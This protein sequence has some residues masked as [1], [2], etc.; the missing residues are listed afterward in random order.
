VT[1]AAGGQAQVFAAGEGVGKRPQT[2]EQNQED[3]EC[4]PHLELMIQD[5]RARRRNRQA[6]V[7]YHRGIAKE[8]SMRRL[9]LLATLV[10]LSPSIMAQRQAPTLSP[11]DLKAAD[12]EFT[13]YIS[14]RLLVLHE[15]LI[16]TPEFIASG[17][18]GYEYIPEFRVGTTPFTGDKEQDSMVLLGRNACHAEV[19]VAR[20]AAPGISYFISGKRGIATAYRLNIEKVLQGIVSAG[21]IVTVLYFGGTI[22]ENGLTYRVSVKGAKQFEDG[23]EYLFFLYKNGDYPSKSFFGFDSAVRVK[24]NIIIP[25]PQPSDDIISN[26]MHTGET[27]EAFAAR[28]AETRKFAETRGMSQ[29]QWRAFE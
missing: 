12:F 15:N 8:P 6:A 17:V 28:L 2:K 16:D 3:G 13:N 21:S 23:E 4:A 26:P 5:A 19:V 18:R 20:V 29:C 22:Q 27:V 24:K 9:F 7:G 1:A 10:C 14:A 11:Q 25:T